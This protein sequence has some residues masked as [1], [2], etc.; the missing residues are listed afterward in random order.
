MNKA[1]I[2]KK[3][4]EMK[5]RFVTLDLLKIPRAFTAMKHEQAASGINSQTRHLTQA[6]G[7]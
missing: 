2:T 7:N 4:T 1:I 6:L 5:H 3:I